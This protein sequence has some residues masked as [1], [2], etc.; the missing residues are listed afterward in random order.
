MVHVAVPLTLPASTSAY[1]YIII[2][3]SVNIVFS[4]P[5]FLISDHSS[6]H[7]N[8]F[9]DLWY[10]I[11]ADDNLKTDKF[12]SQLVIIRTNTHTEEKIKLFKLLWRA[13]SCK[14]TRV[15]DSWFECIYHALHS[16]IVAK[17]RQCLQLILI[18]WHLTHF[19]TLSI[20]AGKRY[21]FCSHSTRVYATL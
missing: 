18:F 16:L 17:I 1:K 14:P 10:K 8:M 2:K 19:S 9:R 11:D 3:S 20:L 13:F 15:L 12:L 7:V 4:M 21:S 6:V 5:L